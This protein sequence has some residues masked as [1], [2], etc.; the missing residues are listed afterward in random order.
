MAK[1]TVLSAK[2]V[3]NAEIRPGSG[4]SYVALVPELFELSLAAGEDK[5]NSP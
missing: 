5:K 3:T 2:G 4:P 1:K